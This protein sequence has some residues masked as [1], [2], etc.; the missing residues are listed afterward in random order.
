M[1][2]GDTKGWSPGARIAGIPPAAGVYLGPVETPE[3][4]PLEEAVAR[5]LIP[6]SVCGAKGAD[7]R[8]VEGKKH[9]LCAPCAARGRRW[10]WA[11][12]GAVGVVLAGVIYLR[13]QSEK[14]PKVGAFSLDSQA[15]REALEKEIGELCRQGRYRQAR[16]LLGALLQRLPDDKALHL[17]MGRCSFNLG[18]FEAAVGHY[19]VAISAGPKDEAECRITLGTS[20]QSLGHSSQ[21]LPFLERAFEGSPYEKGRRGMLAECLLDLERYPEA[22][23]ILDELP[24][25]AGVLRNR[26]RA[27]LYQ[28]KPDEARKVYE[29]TGPG[30]ATVPPGSRAVV[31]AMQAREQGDFAGALKILE[32]ARSTVDP[33][34][35]DALRLRHMGIQ[36]YVDSGDLAKLDQETTEL[37]KSTHRMVAGEA[38]Y[39]R[40][41]GRLMAGKREEAEAVAK[42]FLERMDIELGLLRRESLLLQH[43]AG[44][45][46]DEDLAKEAGLVNRFW[47]NDMYFYLALATGKAEWAKKAQE[48]TPGRNFPYHAI[49]RLLQKK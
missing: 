44:R 21:A 40:A 45:R 33:E 41:L 16:G 6:C 31:L 27:L 47:A 46:K 12:L 23:K 32:E 26:H 1:T 4:I 14:G 39:Y 8:Q 11:A 9:F 17:W 2:E 24:P 36:V 3:K 42:E 13:I 29:T 35:F 22:L 10:M 7:V 5:D 34:S 25:D 15:D 48:A 38:L 30:P 43:L 20:L 18:Y 28:G 49:Q 37:A 19:Q